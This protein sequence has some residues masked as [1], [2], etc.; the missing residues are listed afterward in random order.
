[1]SFISFF[2]GLCRWEVGHT[3]LLL[4]FGSWSALGSGSLCSLIMMS[5]YISVI[6][7]LMCGMDLLLERRMRGGVISV[8]LKLWL[9]RT[10]R[11]REILLG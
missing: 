7:S 6:I 1:M 4:A 8:V 3:V 10:L 5:M 2:N 9:R 11:V